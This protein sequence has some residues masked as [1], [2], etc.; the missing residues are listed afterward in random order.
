[1]S[2]LSILQSNYGKCM[3]GDVMVDGEVIFQHK[4]FHGDLVQDDYSLQSSQR[5]D[6]LIGGV[7]KLKNT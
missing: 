6:F 1:M 5:S 7:L 3:V 2:Q 4:L